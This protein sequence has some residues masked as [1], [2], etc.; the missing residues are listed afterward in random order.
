MSFVKPII[1]VNNNIVESGP[2]Q[3]VD[4]TSLGSGVADNTTFL[5]GDSTWQPVVQSFNTRT[6]SVVLTSGDVTTALAFVPYANTNPAGYITA[7]SPDLTGTPT[8][9]TASANTNTTQLATT[10][11][12]VGQASVASP[13][14]NGSVAVG[15]SLLY[16][17]QD[18]IHPVDTSRAP[19]Y[20]AFVDQGTK[21]SGTYNIVV[22]AAAQQRI[23]N[24]GAFTITTSGWPSSG[25]RGELLIELVNGAAFVITWPTINWIKS[26]GTVTTVISSS[27]YTLQTSG[28]DFI[29]L[30]TRD[31]GTTIYGKIIR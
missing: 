11:Y 9:P 23:Q 31:G 5:R 27:G 26:D 1:L 10:A 17:R 29:L 15:T 20:A 8:A 30:W 24:G 14:M 18:H 7:S 25:L 28:V 6:G 2:G 13:L 4:P 16:S 19:L 3:L 21:S 22:S 12:V